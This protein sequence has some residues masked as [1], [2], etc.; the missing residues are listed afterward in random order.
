M[1][2]FKLI[3]IKLMKRFGF[4]ESYEI[5]GDFDLWVRL[6]KVIS[7]K[8]I[9]EIVELSRRHG[10]NDSNMRKNRWL[11]ERRYF[12]KK[13]LKANSVFRFPAIIGYIIKTEVKGLINAR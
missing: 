13:F 3:D 6:S 4:D 8:G 11:Y 5:M 12:Y 9:N 7:I 2:I 10:S 1:V